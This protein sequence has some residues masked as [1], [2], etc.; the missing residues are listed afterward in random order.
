MNLS[1]KIHF[2]EKYLTRLY[3]FQFSEEGRKFTMQG[4]TPELDYIIDIIRFNSH[5]KS[6]SIS[7][8]A[9]IAHRI[10]ENRISKYFLPYLNR[11]ETYLHTFTVS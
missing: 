6:R 11:K 10:A 7:L 8:E 9:P 3:Q 5:G 4:L 1:D 2:T